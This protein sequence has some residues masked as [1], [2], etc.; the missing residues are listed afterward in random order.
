MTIYNTTAA[1]L[2]NLE[3]YRQNPIQTKMTEAIQRPRQYAI[4]SDI[5]RKVV[6]TRIASYLPPCAQRTTSSGPRSTML[7]GSH[8][9][10]E[11]RRSALGEYSF[12]RTLEWKLRMT[13]VFHR[14]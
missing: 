14:I 1:V 4:R 6:S 9:E 13:E 11:F 3:S 8:S 5:Q 10:G 12:W 2:G 7:L